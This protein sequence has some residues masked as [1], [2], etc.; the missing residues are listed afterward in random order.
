MLFRSVR[1]GLREEQVGVLMASDAR[2]RP[3]APV[4][5]ASIDT[6]RHPQ[7][8]LRKPRSH[9]KTVFRNCLPVSLR[10]RIRS[11]N[12]LEHRSH[13]LRDMFDVSIAINIGP[14]WNTA[15]LRGQVFID[16]TLRLSQYTYLKP[17]ALHFLRRFVRQLQ[18]DREHPLQ[19]RP[20]SAND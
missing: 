12:K 15:D 18:N 8:S 19:R 7:K 9:L 20:K 3:V 6:L 1:A 14:R 10:L 5:V 11:H 4:Q 13:S 2:R 16:I 17:S